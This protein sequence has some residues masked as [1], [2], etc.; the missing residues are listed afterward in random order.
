MRELTATS[1]HTLSNGVI[2]SV[3]SKGQIIIHVLMAGIN[4]PLPRN[5]LRLT[6]LAISIENKGMGEGT[7]LFLV[8]DSLILHNPFEATQ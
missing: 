1:Q 3:H 2:I 8:G 5:F 4:D 7:R 6:T